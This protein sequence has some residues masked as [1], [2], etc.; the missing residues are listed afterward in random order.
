MIEG[1]RLSQLVNAV[2]NRD[3]AFLQVNLFHVRLQKSHVPQH[4]SKRTDD[5]GKVEF[6]CRHFMQ[7][8]SEQHEVFAIDER[9]FNVWI[10]GDGFVQVQRGIQ[11]S[12]AAA[13]DQHA[14]FRFRAGGCKIHQR[15]SF[16]FSTVRK[17]ALPSV[18]PCRACSYVL[19]PL[20]GESDA[21]CSTVCQPPPR[22]LYSAMR[23]A[24]TLRSLWTSL[25]CA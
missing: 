19:V 1:Q 3:L 12:E 24:E 8:G 6:P 4:L 22:A 2:R 25:S 10:G 18:R 7:H 17:A 15:P 21:C 13:Q 16:H 14:C 9:H 5:V 11:S 23:L 20:V